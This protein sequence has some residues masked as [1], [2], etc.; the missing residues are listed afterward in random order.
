MNYI[1]WS[2]IQVNPTN[3]QQ[4]C[5]RDTQVALPPPLADAEAARRDM[6]GVALRT[7][8][9]PAPALSE[10]LGR[11]VLLKME[12]M[13]PSRAFKLRGAATAIARLNPAARAKGVVC[14]STGNHGRAVAYAAQQSG[15][16]AV[17]CLSELVPPNKVAAIEA[18]G[19]EV[20][21]IGR[22]QDE[23]AVEVARLVAEEGMTDIPPFDH[24]DIMAGQSTIALEMLEDRPDLAHLVL[25]LSG[26]G[27]AGGMARVAKAM[28]PAIR[29]TGVSMQHGAAM[30]ASLKAG[31]PVDVDEPHSLADS[32]GG[33]IGLHNRFTFA[34]CRDHIDDHWTVSEAEIY[35]AMQT[36]Y[37]RERLVSE[38][39]AVAGLAA[40]L[41]G[42]DGSGPVGLVITGDAVDMAQFNAIMAGQDVTLGETILKGQ[43]W[44]L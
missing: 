38:G 31:R 15:I 11:E 6:A 5:P 14:C 16:R 41:A 33:G 29:I 18:L 30:A 37:Y 39:G 1:S 24:P 28:N 3:M 19:A 23:A 20:R 22:S 27:L 21:R 32:L 25:Q 44:Q 8:L 40:L 35:R 42:L 9:L 12:T 43:P 17:V 34:A 7:P 26:G 10:M 36:L 13:Q 4:N 2:K